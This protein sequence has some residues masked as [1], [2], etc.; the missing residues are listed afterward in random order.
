MERRYAPFYL[1]RTKEAMV[2]FPERQDDGTW[3]A[4]RYSPNEFLARSA[5]T[6]MVPRPA[7]RDV[8]R[9]VKQRALTPPLNKMTR[10]PAPL[11]SSWHCINAG[12]LRAPAPCVSHSKNRA[13]RL[14]RML[15]EAQDLRAQG[16]VDLPDADD[17]DEMDDADRER[18]ERALDAIT[19]AENAVD[20]NAEVA[21]LRELAIQAAEVEESGTEAK[22]SSLKALLHEEGFFDHSDQRLLIFSEFKDTL[23]YLVEKLT[24]WGFQVGFIHGGMAPGPV[25]L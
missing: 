18:L 23:D 11:A 1:R 17:L 14:E 13:N 6:L 5:S 10:G 20:I 8:T 25:R 4:G 9:Y 15:A 12:S 16:P 21:R 22:L 7:Y 19:I 24:E 2:Y 3:A